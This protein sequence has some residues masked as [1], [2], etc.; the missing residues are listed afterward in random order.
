[1][2]EEDTESQMLFWNQLNLVVEQAAKVKANFFGFMADEA[3]ANWRA[4]RAVYNSG[5]DNEM[6]GRERSCLFHWEQ[7]LNIHTT[8]FVFKESQREHK[9][10]CERWRTAGTKDEALAQYRTIRQWWRTGKV[11]DADIPAMDSWMS[12][13]NVRIAHWGDCMVSVSFPTQ[14]YQS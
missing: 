4:V 2:K 9:D 7:S 11:R 6:I 14:E 13:W 8:K 12:W 5:T 3:Q 1:M 10:M